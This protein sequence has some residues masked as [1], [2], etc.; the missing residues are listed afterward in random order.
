[1]T[2]S[3]QEGS[4]KES[5]RVAKLRLGP[6]DWQTVIGL[7][8]LLGAA[9]AFFYHWHSDI[10]V[11]DRESRRPFLDTQLKIYAKVLPVVAKIRRL[12]SDPA[13][14]A[15]SN[16]YKAAVADFWDSYWGEMAMVE[17]KK[18]ER[19]MV[20]FG[21]SL[22]ADAHPERIACAKSKDEIALALDH[23]TR[24]SLAAGW[25]LQHF[26]ANEYCTDGNLDSL[27][28]ACPAR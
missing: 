1:M 19:V 21:R 17:D 27:A 15:S 10:E 16:E 22:D 18:V 2:A 8:T 24:D 6:V 26:E 9:I 3:A 5:S 4:G 20:L 11:R 14:A 25:G 28:R 7:L 23:C 12:S 13:T